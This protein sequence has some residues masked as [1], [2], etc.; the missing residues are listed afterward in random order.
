MR[1][2]IQGEDRWQSAL[3]PECL[4]DYIA[5]DNPVRAFEV[6]VNELDLGSLNFDG[7]VSERARVAGDI[8]ALGK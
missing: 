6:F 1:R 4:D 8:V 7:A 2:F 3:F 5:D